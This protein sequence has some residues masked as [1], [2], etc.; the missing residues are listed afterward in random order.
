MA[1]VGYFG[2]AVGD[3]VL[4]DDDDPPL[5]D[6]QPAATSATTTARMAALPGTRCNL[7]LTPPAVFLDAIGVALNTRH[8]PSAGARSHCC[9]YPG[10]QSARRY[11]RRASAG[12]DESAPASH[13][14]GWVGR[15]GVPCPWWGARPHGPGRFR[16]PGDH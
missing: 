16:G 13:S 3:A 12:L 4:D 15:A 10:Q 6:P 2:A 11:A 1:L 14:D 7:T 9:P 8:Q 5:L